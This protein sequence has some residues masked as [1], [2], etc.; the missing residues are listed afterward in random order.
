MEGTND[1]GLRDTRVLTQTIAN[2]RNMLNQAMSRNVVPYLATVPPMVR[3]RQRTLGATTV[4][5]LNTLIRQL[6]AESGVT[7]VDVAAAFGGDGPLDNSSLI[8]ADGLHPTEAGYQVIASAFFDRLRATLERMPSLAAG[9]PA[10][11]K[12]P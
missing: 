10:T 12:S 8:G 11:A 3:D 6:A 5:F 1:V 4:P 2:L 7:L 9:S